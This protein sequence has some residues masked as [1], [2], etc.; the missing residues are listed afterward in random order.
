MNILIVWYEIPGLGELKWYNFLQYFSGFGLTSSGTF[1]VSLQIPVQ[2]N[3]CSF[4]AAKDIYT[5]VHTFAT[6]F[7]CQA[8]WIRETVHR[9]VVTITLFTHL[10][11]I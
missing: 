1:M 2:N 7:T 5:N 9:A 4:N 11:G 10:P 3:H 8:N 6:S